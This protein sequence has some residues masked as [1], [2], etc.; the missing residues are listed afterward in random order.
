MTIQVKG[1]LL[2]LVDSCPV[3]EAE[4]LYE[5]LLDKP[6]VKLDL[7]GCQHMHSA[8]LQALLMQPREIKRPPTDAFLKQMVLPRL[9]IAWREAQS[10]HG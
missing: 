8:V 7:S 5:K 3:E 6:D 9:E 10:D 2:K 1:K 4:T